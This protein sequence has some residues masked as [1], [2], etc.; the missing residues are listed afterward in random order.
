MK[1]ETACGAV[2]FTVKNKEIKY[3]IIKS[4]KGDYGFPKGHVEKKESE[5]ETALREIY[6]ETGLKPKIIP[7][8]R[9][10]D[11]YPLPKKKN[12]IKRSV[13]FLA[14]YKDQ[15]I[16]YQKEE[17]KGAKLLCYDKALKIL[18]FNSSKEILKKANKFL[19]KLYG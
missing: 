8:F 7:G 5:K 11:E 13:Y 10:V 4:I 19:K 12:I 18:S 9:E 15:E 2:V 14:K 3:V 17:L 6:E 1:Y 16:V